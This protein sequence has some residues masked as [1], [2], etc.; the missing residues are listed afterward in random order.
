MITLL[1]KVV[2]ITGG[3]RGIGA[4]VATMMAEAGATVAFTYNADK[5]GAQRTAHRV[6]RCGSECLIIQADVSKSDDVRRTVKTVLGHFGRIDILINNAGVWKRGRM[7][8]MTEA[9]WDE[10]LDINLKGTFLFCNEVVPVMRK[11]KG[12]KI[13]NIASTAGQRGEPFYSHYA[14]SKGGAIALTKALGAELAPENIIV[15]C[16][17]P[18]WVHTDMTASVLRDRKQLR[19]I[20]KVIPRGR[21]GT[22]EEIAGPVLFLASDLSNYI[23][24]AVLNVNGGSVLFG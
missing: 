22:P 23:V 20:K 15:N 18:G 16:V 12:G 11:Q 2:L 19:D 17:S 13:V 8:K 5:A 4:A 6:A 21:V 14:A 10:T 24:G 3:S 7:G 1:G 9:Q